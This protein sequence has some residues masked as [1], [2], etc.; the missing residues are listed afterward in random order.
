M[1]SERRN[2]YEH[3]PPEGAKPARGGS[4]MASGRPPDSSFFASWDR[5][6]R[7]G[8][9]EAVV[10]RPWGRSWD[11]CD[12]LGAVLGASWG[13]P[14]RSRVPLGGHFGTPQ[15]LIWTIWALSVAQREIQQKHRILRC[16]WAFQGLPER[17]EIAPHSARGAS[18]TSLGTQDRSGEPKLRYT[19]PKLAPRV[20]L[21]P[22]G[23]RRASRELCH[24]KSKSR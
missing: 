12:A 4:K 16:F 24:L 11:A 9:S 20:A 5:L 21:G 13:V 17:S 19:R 1:L 15:G 22:A 23:N 2:L 10:G 8:R 3:P 18:R 7:Q 6:G 14:G